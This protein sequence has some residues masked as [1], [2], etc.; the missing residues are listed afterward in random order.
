MENRTAVAVTISQVVQKAEGALDV[1]AAGR[2][3]ADPGKGTVAIDDG[4]HDEGR[5]RR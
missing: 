3:A 4:E 5:T 1:V 2:T